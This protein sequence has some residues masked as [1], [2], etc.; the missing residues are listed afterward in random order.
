MSTFE[1]SREIL[2]S[3]D[4]V[5]AAIAT[6]ERLARWWGPAGFTNEF[7][8]CEF[9]PGGRWIFT[10]RGPDGKTYPN[11]HVFAE[12]VAPSKIV[13]QHVSLPKY[14]LTVGLAPSAA[15]C[16]VT[17]TQEFEKPE[18]ARSIAHIVV[19]SNE[20]NLDRLTAEVVRENERAAATSRR[21]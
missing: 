3:V 15:G 8:V 10:M 17:W 19:P 5:F 6:P 1:T 12:I 9:K 16:L 7:E 4:R 21:P 11:E 20:Q 14:R 18:V 2:A 13:V